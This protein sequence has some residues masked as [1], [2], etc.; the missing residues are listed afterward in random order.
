MSRPLGGWVYRRL[1]WPPIQRMISLCGA[2]EQVQLTFILG[3]F[4]IFDQVLH[5]G[6]TDALVLAGLHKVECNRPRAPR[7]FSIP[8][9][10]VEEAAEDCI[11][12]QEVC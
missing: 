6:N 8:V 3:G 12:T 9:S 1:Q 11:P 2:M 7:E 5:L 4:V 10:D